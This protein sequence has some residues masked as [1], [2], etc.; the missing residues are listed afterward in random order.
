MND[1][2]LTQLLRAFRSGTLTP[3]E[4]AE[5]L[6]EVAQ[7]HAAL[8]AFTTFDATLLRKQAGAA[9]AQYSS[10]DTAGPLCGAPIILKDNI[11]TEALPTS[12]GT[13]ALVN[14]QTRH[15]APVAA[16]LHQA[17]AILAGKA[18]LHE[19]SSGGTSNNHTFGGVANPYD[20]AR[21]PGG[22]SGGTAAAVAARIVPAG[23]G[24]DTAGSVRVP[25]AL[26]GIAGLKP[27]T[28]RYPGAGIVPLSSTFD[29]AG[30]IA[31]SVEDIVLLDSVITND[32][33]EVADRDMTD[34]RIGVAFATHVESASAEVRSVFSN[35]LSRL[36]ESGAKIVPIDLGR[37]QSLTK[38][39]A[40]MEYEFL[41]EMN[42]Y[43]EKYAPQVSMETLAKSIASPSLFDRTQVRMAASPDRSAYRR[44]VDDRLPMLRAAHAELHTE[45][46]LDAVVYP[47]TPEVA[48]PRSDDDNVLRNGESVSSWLYF[49][50][51][52]LASVAGNPSLTLP[53]GLSDSGMPVGLLADSL[54]GRDRALLSV[55][56]A[57]EN[58]IEPIPRPG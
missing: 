23:I 52:A 45:H 43:L 15:D 18:N 47:T 27:T 36:D 11:N 55:G 16:R 8:N 5:Q 6:V 54:P 14:N 37:V 21:T 19:L 49:K 53:C 10:A 33:T 29:T 50:T 17:G 4:Y 26:C 51:T 24:T 44:A 38:A 58:L 20:P 42:R 7:E 48:L 35:V 32:F 22:S 46:G 31:R 25:A 9:N 3:V 2:S 34:L 28:G 12:G 13:P 40:I 57:I 1:F 41:V 30:P 56:R 39:A